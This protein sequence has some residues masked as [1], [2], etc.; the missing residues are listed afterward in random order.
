LPL[1]GA[2]GGYRFGS[3]EFVLAA[4]GL[5]GLVI[6]ARRREKR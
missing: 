3:A 2:F 5:I 6:Y 4:L 1:P